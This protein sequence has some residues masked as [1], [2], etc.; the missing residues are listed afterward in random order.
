MLPYH[1]IPATYLR[2]SE[3]LCSIPPGGVWQ[4]HSTFLL[5]CDVVL[6]MKRVTRSSTLT[7]THQNPYNF[8]TH[9]NLQYSMQPNDSCT[10]VVLRCP[11]LRELYKYYE[12]CCVHALSKTSH[13]QTLSDTLS[14]TTSTVLRVSE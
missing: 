13:S 11:Q 2:F 4:V 8:H 12:R 5:H 3:S 6:M 9:I 1:T 14:E 7:L 10:K